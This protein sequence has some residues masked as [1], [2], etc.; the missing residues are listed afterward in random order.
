VNLP[1]SPLEDS[2]VQYDWRGKFFRRDIVLTRDVD[3]Q[4][5]AQ[6]G[7][8][9]LTF[10]VSFARVNVTFFSLFVGFD[11]IVYSVHDLPP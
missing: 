9:V 7:V 4:V 2:I 10:K 8:L 11:V 6:I 5:A 3:T 1:E